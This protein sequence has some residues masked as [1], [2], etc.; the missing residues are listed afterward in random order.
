MRHVLLHLQF[1]EIIPP[2]PDLLFFQHPIRGLYCLRKFERGLDINQVQV[3]C[4]LIQ[5]PFMQFIGLY[6]QAQNDI[7]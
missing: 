1:V 6:E 7:I 4:Q 2:D 3:M 5:L